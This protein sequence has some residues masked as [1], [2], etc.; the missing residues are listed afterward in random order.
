MKKVLVTGAF[1]NIGSLVI[2]E[3]LSRNHQVVA[4]D[5][6]S[7]INRRNAKKFANNDIT[8]LWGDITDPE[9]VNSATS[10]VDA[11]I[12]LAG[13]IPPLSENNNAL[14]KAVNVDGT[15]HVIDAME[16]SGTA[17][18]LV[19][20]SSIAI[21]GKEQGKVPP[22]LTAEHPPSPSDY[23]GESKTEAEQLIRASALDWSIL[24]ISASPPVNIAN[25]GAFLGNPFL[26]LHPDSRVEII[27][28]A[29]TAL[30]FV[31]AVECD[32]AIGETLLLGGGE[33]NR[34]VI[35]QMFNAMFSAM[36]LKPLPREAFQ[37]TEEIDFHGDWLDTGPSQSLLHFQRH[38]P[39]RIFSDLRESLGPARHA[40]LLLKVLSPLIRWGMLKTSPYYKRQNQ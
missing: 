39:E 19:F 40:L 21:Y 11:V 33:N 35:H 24:R 23:Y 34:V 8:V 1:G 13:I 3:L 5:K 31:N 9:G 29:D 27:H 12:H 32:E 30:A 37:I 36:G 10:H 6:D 17:K 25:M 16:K 38:P 22:P 14:A 7:A 26:E 20:A 15:Q 18:R 28:P 2:R 4:F